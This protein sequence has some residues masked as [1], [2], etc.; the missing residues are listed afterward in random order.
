MPRGRFAGTLSPMTPQELVEYV[1]RAL[2]ERPEDVRVRAVETDQ[3][4]AIELKVAPGDLGRIIGRQ[5]RTANA[6]RALV[7]V[8]AAREGKRA[9]VDIS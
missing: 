9:T 3:T 1:A 8:V 2:V 6:L 7:G 5:G 4:L